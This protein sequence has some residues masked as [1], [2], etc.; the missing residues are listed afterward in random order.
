[1]LLLVNLRARQARKRDLVSLP[2]LLRGE[3][4]RESQRK[5]Q[6]DK[7]SKER[8][9]QKPLVLERA[10]WFLLRNLKGFR[11]DRTK[12]MECL[13]LFLVSQLLLRLLESVHWIVQ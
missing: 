2:C 1:M 4:G 12:W 7:W 10:R 5:K 6:R 8:R 13:R 9:M 3:S 11:V